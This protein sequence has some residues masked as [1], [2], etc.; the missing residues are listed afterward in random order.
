MKAFIVTDWSENI[1][2]EKVASQLKDSADV[3]REMQKRGVEPIIAAASMIAGVFKEGGG[4]VFFCGNGGSAADS[5]HLA[6]EFIVRLTSARNRRALPAIALTTNTSTLTA[7]SNDYGFDS[8]F[9]RQVE[10]LG[11]EG[12]ILI[13]ISTS[14]NS[15]NLLKAAE[16][17][18]AIGMKLIGFLGAKPGLLGPMMDICINI[19]AN[20]CQRVQ[21]GHIT[22]GHIIVGLVEFLLFGE[23]ED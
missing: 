10:A 8:V 19:P 20:N 5:Q 11:K 17:A 13:C 16:T 14:G 15:Q 1:L 12:D 3:K 2:R 18:K 23:V 4:T 6:T 7:A 22:A 21:E 9:S